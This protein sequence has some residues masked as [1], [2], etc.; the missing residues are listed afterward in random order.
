MNNED[1][2]YVRQQ[3]GTA[4]DE[5]PDTV[6]VKAMA[7]GATPSHWVSM[8]VTIFRQMISAVRG[9]DEPKPFPH[10]FMGGDVIMAARIPAKPGLAKH[11][12]VIIREYEEVGQVL[13][14]VH[15]LVA[16]RNTEAWESDLGKYGFTT[17]ET[18]FDEFTERMY[19][20][21]GLSRDRKVQD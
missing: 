10:N 14:S 2:R 6:K 4:F 13:F 20:R 21:G 19:R 17:P 8:P 16:Q 18:A 7:P 12:A 5:K 9:D 1:A 11:R 3:L 15:Y